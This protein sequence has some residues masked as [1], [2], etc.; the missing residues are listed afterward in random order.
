MI[1]R[2]SLCIDVFPGSNRVRRV[3]GVCNRPS[4]ANGT[5][6]R[7]RNSPRT[8]PSRQRRRVQLSRDGVGTQPVPCRGPTLPRTMLLRKRSSL[9]R[10]TNTPR[11]LPFQGH[12]PGSWGNSRTAEER[13][14]VLLLKPRTAV[15]YPSRKRSPFCLNHE[16][17]APDFKT[18]RSQ[19]VPAKPIKYMWAPHQVE[20][21][22]GDF[23][24]EEEEK[25]CSWVPLRGK[26]LSSGCSW[27]RSQPTPCF[28][29]CPS[30]ARELVKNAHLWST[31][32]A[33]HTPKQPLKVGEGGMVAK[34]NLFFFLTKFAKQFIFYANHRVQAKGTIPWSS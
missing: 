33:P 21:S 2:D 29:K 15:L 10:L 1:T 12:L 31:V 25:L 7:T 18:S 16:R 17:R 6:Q 23:L 4:F 22:Q 34:N 28:F 19:P 26:R 14:K 32:P 3:R 20:V 24:E 11:G 5:V 30:R 8:T 13:L 9:P 27:P